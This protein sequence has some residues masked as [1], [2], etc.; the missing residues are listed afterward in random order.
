M[1]REHAEAP[2]PR[3]PERFAGPDEDNDHHPDDVL[4]AGHGIG[5]DPRQR[6]LH[7]VL[8]RSR[9]HPTIDRRACGLR[10]R[11]FRVPAGELRRNARRAQLRVVQGARVR[12]PPNRSGVRRGLSDRGHIRGEHALLQLRPL[13]E[14]R[15]RDL[16]QL[17][18]KRVGAQPAECRGQAVNRVVLGRQRAMATGIVH[19]QLEG[20]VDLLGRL[21]RAERALAV[22]DHRIARVHV[23]DVGR[24][25]Q[26]AM[27]GK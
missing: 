21:H 16:I 27:I 11:V 5:H 19:F 17:R 1:G 20:H 15:P 25:D 9:Q 7:V 10:Q 8:R 4:A 2:V 14:R 24:I 26:I 3:I 13:G 23:D 6:A 22:E 18:R 12:E